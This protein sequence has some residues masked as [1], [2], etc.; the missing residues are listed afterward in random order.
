MFFVMKPDKG[1]TLDF[2]FFLLKRQGLE[3]G[4]E[5]VAGTKLV[6]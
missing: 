4:R 6:K 5:I 2:F 3:E 1:S